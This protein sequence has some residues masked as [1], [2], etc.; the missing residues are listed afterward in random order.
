MT[1]FNVY[2]EFQTYGFSEEDN[3]IICLPQTFFCKTVE[4]SQL[5]DFVSSLHKQL[6]AEGV[7]EP[8]V[9]YTKI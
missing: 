3:R 8:Q 7:K 4:S 1:Q 2:L 5:G 9:R 6:S